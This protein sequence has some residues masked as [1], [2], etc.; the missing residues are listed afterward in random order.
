MI[1]PFADIVLLVVAIAVV[2][3]VAIA[4]FFPERSWPRPRK[5]VGESEGADHRPTARDG[6]AKGAQ[7]LPEQG[8]ADNGRRRNGNPSQNTTGRSERFWKRMDFWLAIG[9]WALVGITAVIRNDA[10]RAAEY[11]VRAWIAI[12]EPVIEGGIISPLTIRIPYENTG[13]S[14]ALDTLH[15][16]GSYPFDVVL[17]GTGVPY[18][19]LSNTRWPINDMCVEYVPGPTFGI[20]IYPGSK[21]STFRYQPVD[22]ERMEAKTQSIMVYGCFT[23]RTFG[24]TRQSPYCY[25]WQAFRGLPATAAKFQPC[26]GAVS[27]F[28]AN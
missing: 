7:P 2:G 5:Q 3:L 8:G 18:I 20:P 25:Y 10:K 14:V 4:T 16:R 26:P 24:K 22:V 28:P 23:Y 17:D 19:D 13:K 1:D 6:Y 27:N 15:H 11:D 9:T 12:S 21:S